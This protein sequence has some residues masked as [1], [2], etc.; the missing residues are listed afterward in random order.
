MKWTP[1]LEKFH[2]ND[3]LRIKIE[4]GRNEKFNSLYHLMLS[5]MVKVINRGPASTS[6]D[7]LKKWV[8][9][10]TGRYDVVK[11][12]QDT[13]GG[14]QVAIDWHSTSFAEMGEDE[15]HQF[16]LDTCDLILRELAPWAVNSPE[17]PEILKIINS[18]KPEAA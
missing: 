13:P 4:K 14:H 11:L 6:V 3:R 12:D 5:M 1:E 9:Y 15:F 18:I 17:W 2:P 10:E 8:K 7:K 16:A